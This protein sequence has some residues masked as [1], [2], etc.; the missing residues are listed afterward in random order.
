MD[1]GGGVNIANLRDTRSGSSAHV[2]QG[3][4]GAPPLLSPFQ[5]PGISE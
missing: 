4:C 1:E 3:A 5:Q 2:E